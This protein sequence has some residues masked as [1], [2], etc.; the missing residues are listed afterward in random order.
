MNQQ[1]LL[2]FSD[3]LGHDNDW[4][5]SNFVVFPFH[6]LRGIKSKG[7][8]SLELYFNDKATLSSPAT[9]TLSIENGKHSD[10]TNAIFKSVL[11]A[12]TAI[13]TVADVGSSTY[14]HKY[15]YGVTVK[16]STPVLYYEK[17][18]NSTQ[19]KII[20]IN[21]KTEKLTSMTLANIHSSAATATVF[22]SNT[23]DNWY[24]IKDVVIPTGS[25]LKLESDELDYD[26]DVFNLYVKLA[27]STPVDV[28][29]R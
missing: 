9:V 13:T 27:G 17:I 6:T 12:T 10:V 16:N 25:T 1:A 19:V 28:I 26:A 11:D 15:I 21:T 20:D 14:A 7:K 23:T 29:I 2:L 8:N 5:N 24:I 3:G 4:G 22:L 18:T